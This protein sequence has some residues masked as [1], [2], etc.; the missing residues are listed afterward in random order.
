MAWIL[1]LDGVIWL[2]EEPIPGS[3][4]AIA[5]LRDAGH[6]VIFLTNN[7]GPRVS[8]LVAKLEGMGVPATPDEVVTSAQAAASLLEPGSTALL[9]AGPGV[10][11]ALEA[12]G[13]EVVRDGRRRRG[14]G[15][16][17][18]GL[19]LPPP[20]RRLPRRPPRRPAHRDQRRHHLSHAR[21]PHPRRRRHPGRGRGRGRRG[22]GGRGQALR[23][24]GQA[25]GRAARAG[26]PAGERRWRRHD[27]GRRPPVHRRTDGPPPRGALRPGDERGD[28]GGDRSTTRR[29]TWSPTWPRW[30]PSSWARLRSRRRPRGRW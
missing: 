20:H 26:G 8:E 2:S 3:A 18:P 24:D 1:D 27:P 4:E 13:V 25:A 14:R 6:R 10:R 7:A 22:T 30:W 23:A 16:L 12:R 15:R 17:P 19:R 29:S 5:A 28:G 21:R 9:C 11:E